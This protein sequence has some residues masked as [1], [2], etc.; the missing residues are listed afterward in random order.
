MDAQRFYSVAYDAR[1]NPKVE[2]MREWGDGL[3]EYARWQVLLGIL[4]DCDGV[5]RVGRIVD[6][7]TGE[8]APT[9]TARFLAREMELDAAG[10]SKWLDMAAECGLIEIGLWKEL[11]DVVSEGVT[12]QLAYQ[13]QKSEAGK[14]SA[15]ARR[16][17]ASDA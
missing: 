16:K 10:L 12:E 13:R 2:I 1:H 17:K 6:R 9:V 14:R 5:V 15:E 8:L 7:E 3:V 4:Y 11:G